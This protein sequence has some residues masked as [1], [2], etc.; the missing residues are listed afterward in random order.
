MNTT[1]ESHDTH[2]LQ[3]VYAIQ[4]HFAAATLMSVYLVDNDGVRITETTRQCD[5]CNVILKTQAGREQFQMALEGLLEKSRA[6]GKTFFGPCPFT[7]LLYA[8]V[9]FVEEGRRRGSWVVGQVRIARRQCPP[10][11]YTQRL[12]DVSAAISLHPY[13]LRKLFAQLPEMTMEDFS[14]A[15][16]LLEMTTTAQPAHAP[17]TIRFPTPAVN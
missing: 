16:A 11:F 1:A 17:N 14:A 13:P 4:S 12:A 15:C 7:G 8:C 9:P 5:Y 6:S 10:N 2:F 3:S